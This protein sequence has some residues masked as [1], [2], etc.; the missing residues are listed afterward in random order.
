MK[1]LKLAPIAGMLMASSA[2]AAAPAADI[3]I[4][5]AGASAQLNSISGI[6]TSL[7]KPN[8]GGFQ[9]QFYQGYG[10]ATGAS[11]TSVNNNLRAFRCALADNAADPSLNGKTILFA[12]SAI[13]GSASGVQFVARQLNRK[14]LNFDACPTTPSLTVAAPPAG[15][16]AVAPVGSAQFNCNGVGTVSSVTTQD[17][18]PTFGTSDVEPARFEGDNAPAAASSVNSADL[19]VLNTRAGRAVIFGIF[20]NDKMWLELQK[21]QGL[22]ASTATAP[23]MPT[24]TTVTVVNSAN[25][26]TNTPNSA[27]TEALR[28]TITKAEYRS[29]AQGTLNDLKFLVGTRSPAVAG[30]KNPGKFQLAR[31]VN[32]SGTQAMSNILFLNNSCGNLLGASIPP[33]D[34]SFTAG[35]FVVTEGSAGSN[36]VASMQSSLFPTIGVISRETPSRGAYTLLTGSDTT[37]KAAY[38]YIKLEGVAPT[39]DNVINGSYEFFAEETAQWN[40]N[41][42]TPGSDAEKFLIRFTDAAGTIATLSTLSAETQEGTAALADYN[43]GSPAANTTWIMNSTR[44]GNNCGPSVKYIE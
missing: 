34:A 40:T 39:R 23:I 29:I 22:I 27:F 2:F 32:G 25:V 36:V 1:Y 28:P 30:T 9:I 33:A 8:G 43:G 4:Y 21:R 5:A 18:K 7:C 44:G 3:T 20:A 6:L 16:A 35:N 11:S 12:Y 41:L 42:I 15:A 37:P 24:V 14:F 13:D 17:Q 10:S 31:R 19:A 26:L 38:D